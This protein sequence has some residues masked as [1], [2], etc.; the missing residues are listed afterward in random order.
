MNGKLTIGLPSKGRLQENANAFFARAGLKVKQDGGRGYTGRLDGVANVEIAF[1]SA[2]E[3]AG[4]LEQ[5]LIHLGVTG[6]D[7][8]REKLSSPERDVELLLP[9]G[10]GHADVV[11]AVPQSWID[12]ATMADLDDVAL[13]FHTRRGRRLRVATKYFNLTRDF[14]AEH[15]LTDYRIVESLGAT[16]G[17]PAAGTAEVIVD[18]TS[19]GATLTANNLKV[20]D[21]GTILKSQANLVASLG[22]EWSDAALNAAGEILDRVSAQ[23][24]AAKL[25]EVRF[26]GG[27]D[28]AKLLAE[29]EK[30]FATSVP[31]G[32]GAAPVRIVHCPEDRLYDIVAYLNAKGR[33]TV[34]AARADYVFEAKNP[35]RERLA[36][37]LKSRR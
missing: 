17:A 5:G 6:E 34:T 26:A 32:A 27:S 22:A 3:I 25:V 37:R 35:L 18:I 23:A 29:L 30:R 36:E 19:T 33:E 14:F 16:E 12:V 31:F 8:I 11:V 2:S 24:R 20:L 21:D 7:L 10:F 15:G 1:L 28:D 4:Q 13:A 9:L